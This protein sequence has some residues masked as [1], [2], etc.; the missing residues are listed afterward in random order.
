MTLCVSLINNNKF[1]EAN[2]IITTQKNTNI[3]NLYIIILASTAEGPTERG[4]Y[5]DSESNLVLVSCV[6]SY[7]KFHV[8][9]KRLFIIKQYP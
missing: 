4:L 3:F 9:I 2:H 1:Q 5:R 7:F 8:I 6:L